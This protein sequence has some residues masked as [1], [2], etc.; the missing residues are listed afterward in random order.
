VINFRLA[1]PQDDADLRT[2]LRS[3]GMP[4]WV[5]MTL[6]REPSFF[7]GSGHFG[8]EYAVVA[9]HGPEQELVGMYTSTLQQL[10]VNGRAE[11]V[12]YL[13]G[14]R[15]RPGWRHRIQV[16]RQGFRSLAQLVPPTLWS[17]TS[18]AHENRRARRL[19]EAGLVGLPR[20]QPVGQLV[21]LAI[22]RKRGSTGHDWLPLQASEVP[23]LL[24]FHQ[25]QARQA[26]FAPVLDQATVERL[27]LHNFRVWRQRGAIQAC[28]AYWNQQPV[29]QLVGRHYAPWVRIFRP[30]Y[31]LLA[32][33]LGRVLLPPIGHPL[34]QTF[35][36]F[37][38]FA[39]EAPVARLF[40]QLLAGC[41]TSVAVVGVR[42]GDPLSRW[43]S[44]RLRTQIYSVGPCP[45][46]DPGVVQPEAALL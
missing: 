42:P 26:Q 6:E 3:P 21:T 13:G 46:L 24:D 28:V 2:L 33:L 8:Q 38:A 25:R 22:A 37:L 40:D 44:F 27:G 1:T 14:L 18:V 36:A 45:P 35:L 30:L 10:Y 12:A 34:D 23:E 7:A 32:R 11:R 41:P 31:N 43:A 29:R 15:V 19:L 9:R 39:D 5:D 4:T 17:I 20:Y 16:Q